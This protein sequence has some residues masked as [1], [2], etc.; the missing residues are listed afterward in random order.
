[1]KRPYLLVSIA[2]IV[3]ASG[4]NFFAPPA[5][6]QTL[7]ADYA[8]TS[9]QIVNIRQSATALADRLAITLEHAQTAVRAADAQSTRIAAT[10]LATGIPFV[11]TR[12][13]TPLFATPVPDQ[14]VGIDGNASP[15]FAITPVT[16][17]EGAQGNSTLQ[18]QPSPTPV[19]TTTINPEAP[20]LENILLT[21]AVG[22]DDCPTGATTVFPTNS[23]G[24]YVSALAFNLFPTNIV[25][26]RWLR[27]GV[28]VVNYDWS[29]GFEIEQG[30]IWFY[31]PASDV[32]FSA[33][34]WGVQLELDGILVGQPIAFTV[35]GTAD[36]MEAPTASS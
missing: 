28:E 18:S 17:G 12:N 1:M 6:E 27:E 31:M 19:T 11:D 5:A 29:P 30:C 8:A 22:A 21:Q 33:G 10:L 4:C 2:H 36:A 25:V 9:T 24:V 15:V 7:A 23:E 16:S 13:I 20:R 32:D 35:T 26:S 34:N 3:F 14:I